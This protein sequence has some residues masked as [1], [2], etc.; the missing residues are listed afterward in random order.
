MIFHI[1]SESWFFC[2]VMQLVSAFGPIIVAGIVSATLSSAL[3]SL[4]SAP[5]VFQVM[6]QTGRVKFAS[7]WM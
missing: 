4:I 5:K 6:S 1:N 2:Q 3:A 7:D